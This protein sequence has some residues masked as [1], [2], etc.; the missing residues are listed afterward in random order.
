ML[1][2]ARRVGERIFMPD[3]GVH[4]TVLSI[5][6]GTVRVGVEAPDDILIL[7][8]ELRDHEDSERP[9]RGFKRHLTRVK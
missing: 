3:I 8:D 9:I 4:F 6:G 7:R 2:L 1:V 5:R